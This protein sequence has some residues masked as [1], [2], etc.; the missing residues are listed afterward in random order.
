MFL[1]ILWQVYQ[2]VPRFVKW[3]TLFHDHGVI[4]RHFQVIGI[5]Q[6]GL[7]QAVEPSERFNDALAMAF[8]GKPFMTT[9]FLEHRR[10]RIVLFQVPDF[11]SSHVA[12]ARMEAQV[13]DAKSAIIVGLSIHHE[14]FSEGVL[15]ER[16]TGDGGRWR[17]Y[18]DAL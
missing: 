13:D 16:D 8:L 3:F 17:V 14:I 1:I 4:D 7:P 15:R 6:N 10:T 18:L 2:G 9:D 5:R 11:H 12:I